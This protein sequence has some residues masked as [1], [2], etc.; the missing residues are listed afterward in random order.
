MT[1]SGLESVVSTPVG[2]MHSHD[3]IAASLATMMTG[4]N[5]TRPYWTDLAELAVSGVGALILA[6]VVL[7][8]AWYFG[9]V[10]LPI[11]LVGS[12]YGSSYLFT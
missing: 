12:F 5:I 1:A 9:A 4:R 2:N 8:L 11:F 7:T 10:L 3:L 6:S